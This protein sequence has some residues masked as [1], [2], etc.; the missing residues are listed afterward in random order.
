MAKKFV[1]N[2]RLERCKD[3]EEAIY[4]LRLLN[5][6]DHHLE[7]MNNRVKLQH[8]RTASNDNMKARWGAAS[9]EGVVKMATR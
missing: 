1:L 2:E 7:C 8:S 3:P 5:L 4:L 9:R 6:T